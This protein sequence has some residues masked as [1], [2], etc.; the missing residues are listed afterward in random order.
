M[1]DGYQSPRHSVM[2]AS[3]IEVE[4]DSLAGNGQDGDI[5]CSEN[6]RLKKRAFEESLIKTIRNGN[7]LEISKKITPKA[8]TKC[9]KNALLMSMLVSYELRRLADRGLP[10]F[11]DET[12]LACSVEEF[13]NCLVDPLKSDVNCR[14]QFKQ[15]FDEVMETAVELEQ[16]RFF[17]HP[18]I[19]N[20]KND[21]WYGDLGEMWTPSY[22]SIRRWKWM[23]LDLWCLFD[24]VLFPFVFLVLYLIHVGKAKWSNS[25]ERCKGDLYETY[26][27]YFTT[28]Y[29][30]FIRDTLSYLALLGLHLSICLSPTSVE[31]S[32]LEW[33]ILIFFMGRIVMEI[34]QFCMIKVQVGQGSKDKIKIFDL[35]D[36]NQEEIDELLT[37]LNELHH[38][39]EKQRKNKV[40]VKRVNK[41]ASRCKDVAIIAL[42]KLKKFT[43]DTWNCLDLITMFVYTCTFLLRIVTWS[44]SQSVVNNRSLVVAG[45]LYGLNTMILTFRV[46][47]QVM[48]T[49]KGLGTIQIALFSIIRDIATILWQFVATVIAF[50]FAITK[51]YMSEKSFLTEKYDV[52]PVCSSSGPTCWWTIAKHLCW[53]LLG[54]A[55]LEALDSVD[56]ATVTLA[57]LLYGIFLV[58]GVILLVNMMIALLSNTY[59]RVEDNSLMEWTFKKAITIQTYSSYDPVPVPLNL[60]SSLVMGVWWLWKKCRRCCKGQPDIKT[61]AEHTKELD[62]VVEKLQTSY[63][64][65]YGFSFPQTEEA[66]MDQ[67]FLEA[68][69]NRR[70][71]S[72]T[73]QRAFLACQD[74]LPTGQKAWHSMGVKV[75][76][77]LLLYEGAKSC[78]V[79][80]ASP[81]V[82]TSLLH[83]GA[84]YVIPFSKDFPHFE[85]LVLE[86]GR[87][88]F[89]EV[90]VVRK[91][92]DFHLTPGC[93][94]GSVA[95]HADGNIVDDG[96]EGFTAHRLIEVPVVNRGDLI[97]CTV[98]FDME[99][100]GKV[101]VVFF[102][103]GAQVTDEELLIEYVKTTKDIYPYVG[104]GQHGVQLLAKMTSAD[105]QEVEIL[106]RMDVAPSNTK[107]KQSYNA[108][109]Y[110]KMAV[111]HRNLEDSTVQFRRLRDNILANFREIEDLFNDTQS[112]FTRLTGLVGEKEGEDVL[113]KVDR[114]RCRQELACADLVKQIKEDLDL[115]GEMTKDNLKVIANAITEASQTHEEQ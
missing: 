74:I 1:I 12:K 32:E 23:F 50:S 41:C 64:A 115:L 45:Y 3:V 9:E 87:S 33:A 78:E 73:A 42:K 88:R 107:S 111:I 11:E 76:D 35:K 113:R 34:K 83:H 31:Y 68:E 39:S 97:G 85:V 28:P 49:V 29:F 63:F 105:T 27:E 75:K 47:G 51:V 98:K 112:E 38:Q 89:L 59:Q 19:D 67:L 44:S 96:N 110:G 15:C 56:S 62:K 106:D 79:C 6:E 84:R 101:P 109:S 21:K 60:V 17:T 55:E 7:F 66:K 43:R 5:T 36:A 70:I 30:L 40:E 92:Y 14:L 13:T 71:A 69:G 26:R 52:I 93:Y 82:T 18:V 24:L 57:H 8:F 103:N 4:C 46:F 114:E 102:L 80:K 20:L 22:L 86:T 94:T 2:T 25:T 54:I 10:N 95:Y 81:Q 58:V 77:C 91:G 108:A 100:N 99:S 37:E 53:S 90:G 61:A 65:A 104:M 72:Q 16:K 48:E